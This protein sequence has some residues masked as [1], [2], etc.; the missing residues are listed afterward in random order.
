MHEL[1]GD[2]AILRHAQRQIEKAA[3]ANDARLKNF[4]NEF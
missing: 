4:L 1:K 3:I 2:L